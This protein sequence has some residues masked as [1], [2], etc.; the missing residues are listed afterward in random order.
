MW[1]YDCEAIQIKDDVLEA[2]TYISCVLEDSLKSALMM[3]RI[4]PEGRLR[5]A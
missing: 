2:I 1:V 3:P 4:T 5:A